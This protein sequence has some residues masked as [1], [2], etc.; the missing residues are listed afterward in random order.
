MNFLGK[1][2]TKLM[3]YEPLTKW[4]VL[5]VI[6]LQLS[7]A[8]Y[9]RH[10][11]PTSPWFISCA[12]VIGGTANHNLFPAIHEI[13]H[14]LAFKGVSANKTLAIFANLPIGIP[15]SA[16]FKVGK[17]VLTSVDTELG[18]KYH[19]EHHKHLGE[20]G[21]DTDM[22]SRLEL[23]CL[24]NVLGKAFFACVKFH[25]LSILQFNYDRTEH[26]RFSSMHFDRA[27]CEHRH[28]LNGISTTFSSR[29]HST[30]SSSKHLASGR[31]S[32]Y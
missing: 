7:M 4:I 30:S 13:T 2:V 21:I 10:T 29:L 3:G 28:P 5:C 12:Y 19:I 22:P 9:L 25:P 18:Q 11:R 6:L 15:Y 1:K 17:N 14:N 31:L 8:L 32:T 23:L 24:S 27:L 20:D 16:A 26:F